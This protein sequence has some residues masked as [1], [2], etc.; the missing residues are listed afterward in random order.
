MIDQYI[1][2]LKDHALFQPDPESIL[3]LLYD[4]YCEM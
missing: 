4:A 1:Q 2:I 3:T